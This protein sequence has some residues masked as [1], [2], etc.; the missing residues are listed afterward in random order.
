MRLFPLQRR[1]P[2]H[3]TNMGFC[4]SVRAEPLAAELVTQLP[5]QISA[6]T[7][8]INSEKRIQKALDGPLVVTEICE[9]CFQLKV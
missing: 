7:L 4:N 1:T 2:S 3:A 9:G 5:R 8:C 6:G